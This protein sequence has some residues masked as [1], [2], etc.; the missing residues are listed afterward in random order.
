MALA[1]L[2]LTIYLTADVEPPGGRRGRHRRADRD[3]DAGDRRDDRLLPDRP[4]AAPT[5]TRTRAVM[6]RAGGATGRARRL[7]TRR[8]AG[9]TSS[10][11]SPSTSPRSPSGSVR[12]RRARRGRGG[13]PSTCARSGTSPARTPEAGRAGRRVP[14][15]GREIDHRARRRHDVAGDR[16]D[17]EEHAAEQV[18][19]RLPPARLPARRQP[20]PPRRRAVGD[21]ARDEEAD[22]AQRV[23][24]PH[25]LVVVRVRERGVHRPVGRR[26]EEQRA[27]RLDRP[28]PTTP[29]AW[30]AW[31]S[32]RAGSARPAAPRRT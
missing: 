18:D 29:R 12:R 8:C 6:T 7:R 25:E 24:P 19:R 20:A 17:A 31:R 27:G 14:V 22:R 26:V 11:S 9:P 16:R 23:G 21:H 15:R 1:Q 28:P 30:P 3:R 10:A 13:A 5:T 4:A 32:A 2:A